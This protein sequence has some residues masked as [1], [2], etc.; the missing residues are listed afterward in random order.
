MGN[1]NAYS[2]SQAANINLGQGGMNIIDTEQ[3]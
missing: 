1:M 3:T 2:P